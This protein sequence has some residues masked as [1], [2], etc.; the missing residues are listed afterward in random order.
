MQVIELAPPAVATNLM[1]PS[2]DGPPTLP[3][4]AYIDA[5]M[6]ILRDEPDVEEVLVDEV[7]PLRMAEAQGQFGQ[8]FDLINAPPKA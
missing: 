3:L 7:K 6:A 5:V 2:D 1:P 4:D 8:I